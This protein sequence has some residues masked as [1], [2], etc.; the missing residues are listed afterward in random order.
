MKNKIVDKCLDYIDYIEKG[1]DVKNNQSR[2]R[3]IKEALIIQKEYNNL[4]N[5]SIKLTKEKQKKVNQN[6]LR[7][8]S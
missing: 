8:N 1:I 3:Y 5:H 7:K 6:E 2:I 4:K